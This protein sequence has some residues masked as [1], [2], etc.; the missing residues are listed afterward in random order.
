MTTKTKLTFGLDAA[1]PPNC[2]FAWG[3]RAVY[4]S[5]NLKKGKFDIPLTNRD[6]FGPVELRQ[7]MLATLE[8]GQALEKSAKELYKKDVGNHDDT[9]HTVYIANGY[10]IKARSYG[11]YIYLVAYPNPD[12][13]GNKALYDGTY[14]TES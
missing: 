11:G 12:F 14:K 4:D 5:S 8:K 3:A 7:K 10:V 9:H 2:P 1:L 13:P 6:S